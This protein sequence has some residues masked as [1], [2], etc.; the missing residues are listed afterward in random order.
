MV[1]KSGLRRDGA[2]RDGRHVEANYANE[3]CKQSCASSNGSNCL[4]IYQFRTWCMVKLHLLLSVQEHRFSFQSF[5]IA[6]VDC[7]HHAWIFTLKW[8]D[9]CLSLGKF[10]ENAWTRSSS[11]AAATSLCAN[12][13]K[14][15]AQSKPSFWNFLML[16]TK[17]C[18]RKLS[19]ASS[20][21]ECFCFFRFLD[22]W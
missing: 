17:L 10:W 7:E 15:W 8:D 20:Q 11:A 22:H 4:I 6:V 9:S 12:I 14:S 21:L 2:Y 3:R 1:I 18:T 19:A 5:V 13:S 16:S